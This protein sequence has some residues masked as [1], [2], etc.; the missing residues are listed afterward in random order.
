MAFLAAEIFCFPPKRVP[1]AELDRT[2]PRQP[3]PPVAP[4]LVCSAPAL[5]E[6]PCPVCPKLDADFE[7]WRQAGYWK[8][9]H[10]KAKARQQQLE[11][12]NATLQA[13]IRFLEQRLF[14]R[15][16]ETSAQVVTP[17]TPAG[18]GAATG[19]AQEPR[20]RGQQRGRPGP[21]RRDYSHLPI[22]EEVRDLPA[23]QQKCQRCGQAFAPFPGTADATVL[24]VEV[25]AHRRLIHRRRYRPT[26]TCG[27][28][29]GIVTAPPPPK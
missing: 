9:L 12:E 2:G 11:L 15:K 18:A 16:S 4:A 10:E 3:L 1:V 13:R 7:P 29:P 26:C 22:R 24:E 6:G 25:R 28:H 17:P 21:K 27:C 14:G 8:K 19:P 20:R 23:D 5:P